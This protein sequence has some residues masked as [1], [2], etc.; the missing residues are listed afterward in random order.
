MFCVVSATSPVGLEEGTAA[1]LMKMTSRPSRIVES[2]M[3][4]IDRYK[5]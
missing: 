1:A 2:I 5:W 3:A 4:A